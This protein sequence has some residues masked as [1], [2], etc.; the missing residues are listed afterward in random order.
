MT[1]VRQKDD[2][3]QQLK[4]GI[5]NISLRSNEPTVYKG[6]SHRVCDYLVCGAFLHC[7]PF[8]IPCRSTGENSGRKEYIA[9]TIQDNGKKALVWYYLAIRNP[10]TYTW[11]L[12]GFSLVQLAF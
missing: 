12:A 2:F 7:P 5:K 10:Y 11:S 8:Y 9:G 1:F 6:S 4:S 3:H